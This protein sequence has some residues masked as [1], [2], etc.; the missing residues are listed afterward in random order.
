MS[1]P[2]HKQRDLP[3]RARA[4]RA[5]ADNTAVRTVPAGEA[6]SPRRRRRGV[7]TT[8]LPT[9]TPAGSTARQVFGGLMGAIQG[10]PEPSPGPRVRKPRRPR[11]GGTRHLAQPASNDD[12][13]EAMRSID[14]RLGDICSVLRATLANDGEPVTSAEVA[15]E[16]AALKERIVELEAEN[17]ELRALTEGPKTDEQA[18]QGD[19]EVEEQ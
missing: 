14:E 3:P 18:D 9:N 2:I 17:E 7:A 6:S 8:G 16:R 5:T 15:A 4:R 10:D 19:D 1:E 11:D 13:L 12:L